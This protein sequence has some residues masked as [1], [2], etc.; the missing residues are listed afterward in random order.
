MRRTSTARRAGRP[1]RAV[2][3]GGRARRTSRPRRVAASS[4]RALRSSS[5]HL[6]L[7]WSTRRSPAAPAASATCSSP[8]VA[9]SSSMPSSQRQLGHGA[10]Q[11]RLRGVRHAV[12]RRRRPPH[13]TGRADAPRRRR[14]AA[15][16]TRAASV[17]L[18]TAADRE[19]ALRRRP[20]QCRAAAAGAQAG[21][22]VTST[23]ARTHRG[24]R[25]RW[26][27]RCAADSTSHSRAWVS[28]AGCPRR[29]RS[30]RGRSR[31]TR[32]ASSRT[33]VVILCGARSSHAIATTSGSSDSARST[34]SSRSWVSS[35]RSTLVERHALD[36]DL[37]GPAGDAGD[38]GVGH[39]DVEDRVLHRLRGDH[40]EIDGLAAVERLQQERAD[41]PHPDRPR[42]A[43]RR[44][45]RDRR[46]ASTGAPARRDATSNTSWPRMISSSSGSWPRAC[47]ADFSRAT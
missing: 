34:S 12:G 11:E 38:A 35:E 44:A 29:S 22:R 13:G 3:R 15:C 28:S 25:A 27:A 10:A 18:S 16:R 33:Q 4:P 36:A 46:P 14:T 43:R 8:P 1:A 32:S 41:G 40:V 17:E 42:R 37:R 30:S 39:L 9:T 7:P 19:P 23:L 26:R 45:T 47:I 24:G 5:T 2:H 20:R 6:L 21:S 31:G